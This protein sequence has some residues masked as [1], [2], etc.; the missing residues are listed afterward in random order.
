MANCIYTVLVC[1]RLEIDQRTRFPEFGSER[2]VGF[3]F[4]K[5]EAFDHVHNNA[6][7]ICEYTYTYAIIEEVYEGFYQP[8]GHDQRWFF[9]FDRET[10]TYEPINEPTEFEHYVGFT[11]G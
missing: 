11:I 7:D 5:K 1:D 2:L 8:A 9:K 10:G 6:C 4:D 3:Y